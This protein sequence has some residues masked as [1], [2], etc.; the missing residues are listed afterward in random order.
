MVEEYESVCWLKVEASKA[1]EFG[2]QAGKSGE[3]CTAMR[4]VLSPWQVANFKEIQ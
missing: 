1:E 2:F 3:T 4:V